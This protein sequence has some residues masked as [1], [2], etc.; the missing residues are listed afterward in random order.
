MRSL[1]ANFCGQKRW[2]GNRT[3]IFDLSK[4]IVAVDRKSLEKCLCSLDAKLFIHDV[5]SVAESQRCHSSH[6]TATIAVVECPEYH[7]LD[8]D[9]FIFDYPANRIAVYSLSA[10]IAKQCKVHQSKC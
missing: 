8:S 9:I 2:S 3:I 6:L 7:F 10:L 5:N 4:K 1:P